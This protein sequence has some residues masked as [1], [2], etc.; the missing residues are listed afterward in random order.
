MVSV[1]GMVVKPMNRGSLSGLGNKYLR[2]LHIIYFCHTHSTLPLWY[3]NFTY[4][5]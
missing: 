1:P 3:R 2:L 5:M 4:G